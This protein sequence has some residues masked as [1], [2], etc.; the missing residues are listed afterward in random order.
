MMMP[1]SQPNLPR[2]RNPES[3]RRSL[4]KEPLPSHGSFAVL[5][6]N[7]K[8]EE[9]VTPGGDLDFCGERGENGR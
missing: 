8:E 6:M 4:P 9:S 2:A 5:R 7:H 1:F 3:K